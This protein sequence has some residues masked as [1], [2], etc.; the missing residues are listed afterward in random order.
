MTTTCY[1]C[2]YA[3]IPPRI[4]VKNKGPSVLRFHVGIKSELFLGHWREE[5]L[6]VIDENELPACFGGKKTDPDGD[7][8]CRT[9]VRIKI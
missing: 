7:P 6:A 1:F 2:T 3:N 4:H 9:W 8:K 5:L